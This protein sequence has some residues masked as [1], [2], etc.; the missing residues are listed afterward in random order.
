MRLRSD[1]LGFNGITLYAAQIET[2]G[3]RPGVLTVAEVHDRAQVFLNRQ[4]QR[5]LYVP[6]PVTRG[7]G[8]ELVVMELHAARARAAFVPAAD[9]GRAEP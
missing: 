5:T 3:D 7:H 6:G 4:P 9:L 8:N 1:D 2:G